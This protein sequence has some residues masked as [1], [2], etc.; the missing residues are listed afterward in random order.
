[1]WKQKTE[2]QMKNIILFFAAIFIFSSCEGPAGPQGPAG[3]DGNA[4]VKCYVY[5]N[6]NWNS[7]NYPVTASLPCAAI[8]SEIMSK[9]LV[10]GYVR[11]TSPNGSLGEWQLPWTYADE[12]GYVENIT[13]SYNTGMA[14]LENTSDD[15]V[16][17]IY[18][19]VAAVK[20]VVIEGVSGKR[21]STELNLS[22]EELIKRYPKMKYVS[23]N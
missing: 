22:W 2:I 9:G 15:G 11:Y 21:E 7:S 19:A 4:N 12:A 5:N 14:T 23:V 1:M 17:S 3:L 8:T 18:G 20:I 6:V 13:M 16:A 10:L